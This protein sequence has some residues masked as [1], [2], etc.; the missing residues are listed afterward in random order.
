MG[1]ASDC[2]K[3]LSQSKGCVDKFV[4]R[5]NESSPQAEQYQPVIPFFSYMC[6]TKQVTDRRQSSL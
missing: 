2:R 4:T 6:Y 3:R 5:F 1:A